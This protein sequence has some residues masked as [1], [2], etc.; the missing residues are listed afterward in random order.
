MDVCVDDSPLKPARALPRTPALAR[1]PT[2]SMIVGDGGCM[3]NLHLLGMLQRRIQRIVMFCNFEVV[4]SS[5]YNASAAPPTHDD[6]DDDIPAFFGVLID[7][8][9]HPMYDINRNQVFRREDFPRLVDALQASQAAGSGAI[10]T[11]NLT[12][13]RHGCPL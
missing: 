13:V 10:A 4:L 9:D 8:P 2:T 5:A 1:P 6:I 3:E 12:T 7:N 11:M